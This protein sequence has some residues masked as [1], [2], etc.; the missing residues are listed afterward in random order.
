MQEQETGAKKSIGSF[1][2]E[3]MQ[4]A[5]RRKKVHFYDFYR[6]CISNTV[7]LI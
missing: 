2:T 4:Y 1:S 6:V 5:R 3:I 7:T